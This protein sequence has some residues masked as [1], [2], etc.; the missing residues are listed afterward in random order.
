M[1]LLIAL[2]F[3]CA[4]VG[5]GRAA[6]ADC[7][8]RPTPGSIV[9]VTDR[10]PV[11]GTYLFSGERGKTSD[12]RPIIT[13]GTA[14]PTASGPAVTVCSSRAAFEN[15]LRKRF[16]NLAP[17]RALVYVHGYY[18]T[19]VQSLQTAITLQ[20]ALRF[21][22]PVIVY[23][24]PSKVT[25]RLSYLNDESNA[26]WSIPHFVDVIG[27]LQRTFP[28]MSISLAS[29][30][31][32]ARFEVAGLQ[33]LRH[34]PCPDCL[35][36]SVFFAPDIDSDT[37][38]DEL[39][40]SRA[41]ASHPAPSPI[42]AAT[43]ALYVSNRDVALRDSQALH[44]HQRAGEAGSEIILCSGVD[45]ID[46]S[47]VHGDDPAGHTYVVYPDVTADAAAAFAGVAPTA[48]TRHLK[49]AHRPGGVYYELTPAH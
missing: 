41:C 34:S 6:L 9:F 40:A 36:R 2:L 8:T 45:T 28:R 1:R 27:Q 18:T 32:G 22:G 29:H 42:A 24:W 38:L 37:L 4:L 25:S 19:F 11:G 12:R 13:Y 5:T 23:S 21:P 20:R 35:G 14:S 15:A 44:G 49:Q 33:F 10:E 26:N 17:L 7:D 31:M 47:Y 30:S 48:H 46:V 3:A 43:F 16:P 39:V